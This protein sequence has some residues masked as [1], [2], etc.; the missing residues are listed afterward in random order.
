MFDCIRAKGEASSI[1]YILIVIIGT[2]ILMNL[3]LAIMLGNFDKARSF[4]HKREILDAFDELLNESNG[5]EVQIDWACDIILGDLADY[6]KYKVLKLYNFK[7]GEKQ[8]K[9]T[10]KKISECQNNIIKGIA[11]QKDLEKLEDT[12][13]Q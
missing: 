5:G 4:G 1:Y 3:F 7:S 9:Q 2:I 10:L 11:T 6:A 13:E 12:Y 8:I